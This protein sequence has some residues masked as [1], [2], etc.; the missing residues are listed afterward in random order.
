M[1]FVARGER[2]IYREVADVLAASEQ[3]GARDGPVRQAADSRSRLLPDVLRWADARWG[4]IGA[5]GGDRVRYNHPMTQRPARLS[6][7]YANVIGPSSPVQRAIRALESIVSNAPSTRAGTSESRSAASLLAV[8]LLHCLNGVGLLNA[9]GHH[10]AAVAMFRPIEDALDCFAAVSLDADAAERWHQGQL[11]ASDAAKVWVA[12]FPTLVEHDEFTLAEYRRLVR[13]QFN[14]YSHCHPRLTHW[15][16]YLRPDAPATATAEL[17]V[18]GAVIDSCGHRIDAHLT[19]SL[20]EFIHILDVSLVG[21]QDVAYAAREELDGTKGEIATILEMHR[22]NGCF[23][24]LTAPEFRQ[25]G[26]TDNQ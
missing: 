20:W 19:A 9:A 10:S 5:R 8:H 25:L 11:K 1:E 12:I 3:I 7:P 15:N 17:N 4:M 14:D 23:D 24:V 18:A 26:T 22:K 16:L 13:S 21:I 2:A 6:H